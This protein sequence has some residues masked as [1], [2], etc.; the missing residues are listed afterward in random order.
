MEVYVKMWT[1]ETVILELAGPGVSIEHVKQAIEGST[2]TTVTILTTAKTKKAYRRTDKPSYIVHIVY[3]AEI[4]GKIASDEDLITDDHFHHSALRVKLKDIESEQQTQK[5]STLE[6]EL[7]QIKKQYQNLQVQ[8][9]YLHQQ[10]IELQSQVDKKTEEVHNTATHITQLSE[11]LQQQVDVNLQLKRQI[12]KQNNNREQRKEGE[13]SILLEELAHYKETSNYHKLKAKTA[14]EEVAMLKI[15]VHEDAVVLGNGGYG[16]VSRVSVTDSTTTDDSSFHEAIPKRVALKMMFNYRARSSS[17]QKS[18]FDREYEVALLYPHWSMTNVYNYFR[19]DI[20]TC[21]LPKEML[22]TCALIDENENWVSGCDDERRAIPMYKRTTFMTMELGTGSLESFI[23]KKFGRSPSAQE[24][25]PL[26]DDSGGTVSTNSSSRRTIMQLGFCLLSAI[27]NINS[28]NW[29]HCDIKTDNILSMEREGIRGSMWVLC[30]LGTAIYSSSPSA[31]FSVPKGEFISGNPANRSPEVTRPHSQGSKL[32]LPLE[33][34]DVWATGCVLYEAISGV[35]PFLKSNILDVNNMCN[36]SQPPVIPPLQPQPPHRG[37]YPEWY[38]P[39]ASLTAHLLERD[40]KARPNSTQAMLI[41]GAL[42]FMPEQAD[43]AEFYSNQDSVKDVLI[44]ILEEN[45]STIT[46]MAS[47]TSTSAKNS[48]HEAVT[49]VEVTQF[50]CLV[51]TNLALKHLTLF[52]KTMSSFCA[53]RASSVV[54]NPLNSLTGVNLPL[55]YTRFT[56]DF[57]LWL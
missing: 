14:Q 50:Y 53:A 51:F 38:A 9:E 5:I 13:F 7:N 12:A 19:G 20:Q 36:T 3:R 28:H 40:P 1:E 42:M 32:I 27:D 8:V 33:K 48:A 10:S 26:L 49:E 41:C 55:N 24:S 22:G 31:S 43:P 15:E 2:T 11:Q 44:G 57:R 47:T 35:H 17:T 30:D 45:L 16:S 52:C 4:K 56:I 34:N 54:A 25:N 39:A 23:S 37:A 46:S 18:E 6:Q 29:F 21:L